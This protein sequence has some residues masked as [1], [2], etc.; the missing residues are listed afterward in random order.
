MAHQ[1]VADAE[2]LP[3]FAEKIKILNY[4]NTSEVWW[5]TVLTKKHITI[6]GF[7]DALYSYRKI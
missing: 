5:K 7:V 3:H 4:Q 1:L 6:T 2:K